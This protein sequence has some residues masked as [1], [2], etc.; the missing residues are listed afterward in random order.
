MKK[1]SNAKPNKRKKRA[2][3][4][5]L[6]GLALSVALLTQLFCG[7]FNAY[8]AALSESD[9]IAF[10]VHA[11]VR[12]D[13]SIYY[14]LVDISVYAG[15]NYGSFTVIYPSELKIHTAGLDASWIVT[16]L[17][18]QGNTSF[19]WTGTG[20]RTAAQLATDLSHITFTLQKAG[21]LP[22]E[23]STIGITASSRK[24]SYFADSQGYIHIYEFVQ[25]PIEGTYNTPN[26]TNTWLKAY[27]AAK[28]MTSPAVYIN[29]QTEPVYM[30][31]YLAT[32]TSEEE[33]FMI[34]N[35]IARQGGWI[36]G[37]RMLLSSG[38]KIQDQDSI[39]TTIGDY[40]FQLAGT[41]YPWGGAN[42]WYWADGPEAFTTYDP[43]NPAAGYTYPSVTEF[44]DASNTPSGYSNMVFWEYPY[45][46]NLSTGQVTTTTYA[47]QA[48]RGSMNL[49]NGTYTYVYTTSGGTT[50]GA[51]RPVLLRASSYTAGSASNYAY[52]GSYLKFITTAAELTT[53]IAKG[54]SIYSR[55]AG[56]GTSAS[57]YIYRPYTATTWPANANAATGSNNWNQVLY[58]QMFDE[59]A[60]G[61]GTHVLVSGEHGT[62]SAYYRVYDANLDNAEDAK[63]TPAFEMVGTG[64]TNAYR[65]Y[66]PAIGEYRMQSINGASANNSWY[67]ATGTTANN[68]YRASLGQYAG[69]H[70]VTTSTVTNYEWNN[71]LPA[72][73]GAYANWDNAHSVNANGQAGIDAA[74]AEPNNNSGGGTFGGYKGANVTTESLSAVN[75][76]AEYVL[77]FAWW[78]EGEQ[79]DLW[80]DA[81]YNRGSSPNQGY[82]VEYGGYPWDPKKSDVTFST[83][84]VE[85]PIPHAVYVF[86]RQPF[87]NDDPKTQSQSKYKYI[88]GIDDSSDDFTI[89]EIGQPYTFDPLPSPPAG[90]I[91]AGYVVSAVDPDKVPL[92][93]DPNVPSPPDPTNTEKYPLGAADEQ[94]LLE[95]AYY[96]AYLESHDESDPPYT[97]HGA[98][99]TNLQSITYFYAPASFS[100]FFDTNAYVDAAGTIIDDTA[101]VAPESKSVIYDSEYGALPVPTRYG[102]DFAGWYDNREGTGEAYTASSVVQKTANHWLYAKWVPKSNYYVAYNVN[103][104]VTDEPIPNKE[105]VSWTQNGLLPDITPE[106]PNDDMKFVAW[107]VYKDG[108]LIIV[109]PQKEYRELAATDTD[110]HITL[111]AQW[112]PNNKVYYD[113]DGGTTAEGLY[114][115]PVTDVI[116]GGGE[117]DERGSKNVMK[118]D[119]VRPGYVF[120]GW[121]VSDDGT[122]APVPET[123]YFADNG[124]VV[125]TDLVSASYTGDA[126]GVHYVVLKAVWEP[127]ATPHTVNYVYNF[128]SDGDGVFYDEDLAPEEDRF[129]VRENVLLI[130]SH[131]VPAPIPDGFDTY[132]PA[133]EGWSFIGWNT[134]PDG[135]GKTVTSVDHYADLAPKGDVNDTITL[136]AQWV[137]TQYRVIYDMNGS[138]DP[139]IET[140]TVNLHDSGFVDPLNNPPTPPAGYSFQSWNVSQNGYKINVLPEDTFADLALN[141]AAGSITLKAIWEPKRNYSVVYDHNAN[142]DPTDPLSTSMQSLTP[143]KYSVSWEESGLIPGYI[144][145]RVGYTFT[146][147]NTEIDADGNGIGHAVTAQ[148]TYG[149]L[150]SVA[151]NPEEVP[152]DRLGATAVFSGQITLYATWV[153]SAQYQVQ[154]DLAGG[155]LADGSAVFPNQTLFSEAATVPLP[156][157]PIKSGYE[158][159]GWTVTVGAD[160]N[161]PQYFFPNENSYSFADLA[162]DGEQVIRLTANYSPKS[163]T[164]IYNNNHADAEEP[165]VNDSVGWTTS[166]LDAGYHDSFR[167]HT[168]VGWNTKIDGTGKTVLPGDTYQ[169]LA[170]TDMQDEIDVYEN[171]ELNASQNGFVSDGNSG[172]SDTHIT[173][174]A[175]WEEATYFV[176]YDLG[177]PEADK[178]DRITVGYDDD[179]LLP[180]EP[181]RPGYVFLRWDVLS[182]GSGTDVSR[183][184]TFSALANAGSY[185][186]TLI[187]RW[188]QLPYSLVVIKRIK[189]DDIVSAHGDPVFFITIHS[190]ASNNDS[191][192]EVNQTLYVIFDAATVTSLT[193]DAQ[194]Y[195]QLKAD[196]QNL[197][198]GTYTVSESDSNRYSSENPHTVILNIANREGRVTFTN[199]KTDQSGTSCVAVAVNR[200]GG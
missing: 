14:E 169:L 101:L 79:N 100:V 89:G 166:G 2:L 75:A 153:A 47:A 5:R 40:D 68:S 117:Q 8:A 180:A 102:Y 30:Q 3:R 159:A 71:G 6:I 146:G 108:V 173:L 64:S 185:Q 92:V 142:G 19:I 39:S 107:A 41:A 53:W 37:T 150:A 46:K 11:A 174:Y 25:M 10:T 54:Y 129:S 4:D 57:P 186:I 188:E 77:M 65:N 96:N 1:E 18:D 140:I 48:A 62:D 123:A 131:L 69:S 91:Y 158:F 43:E 27:N 50:Y 144:L 126:E 88:P 61:T 9:P 109:T 138:P 154:Y 21:T 44:P 135:S 157:N 165:T 106:W 67:T 104:G 199:E 94:Y 171:P 176:D 170:G 95:L 97:I 56:A 26:N 178:I 73:A 42:Q 63:Y 84:V 49:V 137:Q 111:T 130:D 118:P 200:I 36:G 187:A 99:S 156:T 160:P 172:D 148:D 193:A 177:Y 76:N 184:D 120:K 90:Y 189:L 29:G 116:G 85:Q 72:V 17:E 93:I 78:R 182:G 132:I 87:L 122:G 60:A 127:D 22:P 196:F 167:G 110:D 143:A 7:F 33:Q 145:S 34:F 83:G 112:A 52:S 179:N 168:F 192:K 86:Y 191:Q 59:V 81:V 38:E 161:A 119:P 128:D 134:A 66:D 183:S 198:A 35:S 136:Y 13:N 82:Y 164:V 155:H 139:Q 80:N 31:G 195:V 162:G 113:L 23:K 152:I 70:S 105:G 16:E 115:I 197:P 28:S 181:T 194:G 151:P 125:F 114:S 32:I 45:I 58:I 141:P 163:F 51:Y 103:G 175:Q 98:I 124:A 190:D 147:W 55:V 24:V 15:V 20:D 74:G 12:E 121:T 133:R 149:F